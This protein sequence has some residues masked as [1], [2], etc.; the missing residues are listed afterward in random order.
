MIIQLTHFSSG[1]AK[2]SSAGRGIE[3]DSKIVLTPS[4]RAAVEKVEKV[5]KLTLPPLFT[6]WAGEGAEEDKIKRFFQKQ[7]GVSAVSEG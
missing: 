5:V 7:D 6:R 3:V 4:K 2:G 1:K